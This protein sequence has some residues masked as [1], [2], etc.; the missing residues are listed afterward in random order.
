MITANDLIAQCEIPLEEKWGY[1]WGASGQTWTQANQDAATDATIR[2]YGQQWVGRRVCDCS[3]LIYWAMGQLGG[4]VH[5][6]SN[7]IWNY[8]VV[9]ATKGEL[10]D[11]KELSKINHPEESAFSDFDDLTDP[12]VEGF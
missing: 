7:S 9:N 6:G 2:E 1:I 12:A 4:S 8:D 5:H 11:G 3:G 10:K